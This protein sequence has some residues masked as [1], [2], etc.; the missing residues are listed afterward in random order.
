[1]YLLPGVGLTVAY[2]FCGDSLVSTAIV[3]TDDG[4]EPADCCGENEPEE[5]CCHTQFVS[6]KLNELHFA[7]AKIQLNELTSDVNDYPEV[8]NN[9]ILDLQSKIH[10]ALQATSPPGKNIYLTNRVL[11]I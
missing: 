1:M 8:D 10:L 3:H 5:G 2:H 4:K 6:Y 7:S 9:F 11:L